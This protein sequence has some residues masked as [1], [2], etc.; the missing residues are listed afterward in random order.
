[1]NKR[2]DF[3]ALVENAFDFLREAIAEFRDKPKYSIIHFCA[4]VELIL[5]ARLLREHWTLVLR[6]PEKADLVKFKT[7]DFLSISVKEAVLR[8]DNILRESKGSVR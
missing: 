6:Q 4:A 8:L 2:P 7:G 1:M 5:K 3:D